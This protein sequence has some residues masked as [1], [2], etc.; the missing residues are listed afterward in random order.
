MLNEKL[1]NPKSIVVIGA[2]NNIH[3]PGGRVLKN[4]IDHH[5]EGEL[6]AVNPKETEVQGLKCYKHINEIQTVDVAIIAISTRSRL[7][8]FGEC[9]TK[10]RPLQ[11]EDISL[12]NWKNSSS[13]LP[14]LA[15]GKPQW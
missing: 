5:F 12:I 8:P 6:L 4:L 15:Q 7:I 11:P 14:P 9:Q 3:T 10:C 1:L 2:S 13:F